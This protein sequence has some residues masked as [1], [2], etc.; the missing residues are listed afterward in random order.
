MYIFKGV[1]NA[2]IVDVKKIVEDKKE[3][4]KLRVDKLKEKGKVPKLAIIKASDDKASDIYIS[5]KRQMCKE[6]G[7]DELEF[8]FDEKVK[9]EEI[10]AKIHKLNEDESVDGI[11][12]QIPLFKH[13]NQNEV[14]DAISPLKDAD[15]LTKENFGNLI[16]GNKSIISCTPKGIVNII[17]KLN[18]DVSG[19]NVT[20]IGRSLLVGKPIAMLLLEKNATVT[21]CH[22]RTRNLK[23]HTKNADILIVAAGCPKLITDDM[24][25][26][27]AVVIDVGITRTEDGIKGDVDTENVSKVAG[28][29]TKVP[30]GVG[31][32]TV[33]SLMEN[34]IE[35]AESKV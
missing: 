1:N 33:V 27:G 14:I 20:V 24:V 15:G 31:L 13:I 12:V 25:K 11:M 19:M 23:E 17:D 22:S 34:V 30:G 2:V 10:I 35:I 26:E 29:I 6:L 28:Y 16:V 32:T 18:I 3:E 4:L 8:M 7:I 5:K 21:V 9:K